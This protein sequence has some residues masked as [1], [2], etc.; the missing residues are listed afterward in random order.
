LDILLLY[1]LTVNALSLY[2]MLADKYKARKNAWR[3]PEATLLGLAAIGGSLGAWLGMQLFRHKTR[4]PKFF[5]GIPVLLVLHIALLL[6][7]MP[8]IA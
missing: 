5:I 4:H 3:I 1:L 7:L 8:K 6:W 2:F